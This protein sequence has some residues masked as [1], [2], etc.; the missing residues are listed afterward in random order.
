MKN[1]FVRYEDIIIEEL[2][3]DRELAI[4][5]LKETLLEEDPRILFDALRLVSLAYAEEAADIFQNLI[6]QRTQELASWSTES[7]TAELG[8][9]SKIIP[10][11]GLHLSVSQEETNN[12]E[13]STT[14]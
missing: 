6:N 4:L 1:H 10:Q 13:L 7:K 12:L 9:I 3:Q 14:H 5:Y 8:S 11:L 2:K